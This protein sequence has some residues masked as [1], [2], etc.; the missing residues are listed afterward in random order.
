MAATAEKSGKSEIFWMNGVS[1][2]EQPLVFFPGVDGGVTTK[3]PFSLGP[4]GTSTS[5]KR[6][7]KMRVNLVSNCKSYNTQMKAGKKV[8]HLQSDGSGSYTKERVSVHQSAAVPE[9]HTIFQPPQTFH[10]LS[11]VIS[12]TSRNKSE[13]SLKDLCLADKK[14]IANLVEELARVSEEKEESVQR[15]KD[16]QGNFGRKIHQLEQQNVI[17]EQERKSLQQQYRECQEL[18]GLYQQY[19]SQQQAK[20]NESIA[21]VSQPPTHSKVV[22]G[23]GAP[24]RTSASRANGSLSDGSYVS[25]AA[26]GAQQTQMCS[27]CDARSGA[28][29][30]LPNPACLSC[31]RELG[32][33]DGSAE[34]HTSQRRECRVPR[35]C[36]RS[37]R[38]KI[39]RRDT[40]NGA[41]D[42][43]SDSGSPL[44]NNHQDTFS[45]KEHER[46]SR[47]REVVASEGKDVLTRTLLGQE[48]WEKKRHQLLLQ[49][50]QLEM[51]RERLQARLTEQEERL[52][53]QTKSGVDCS[54]TQLPT[55]A[56]LSRL[57]TGNG[58]P[59]LEGSSHQ[60]LP[61]SVCTDEET[62]S[63]G[64]SL[65][66]KHSQTAPSASKA[67]NDLLERSRKDTGTSPLKSK[68]NSAP[69]I[70]KTPQARLDFSV[71]ELLDIFSPISTSEQPKPSARRPKTFRHGSTFTSSN[72]VGRI[73]LNPGGPYPH[74]THQDLEESQILEDIF[75]IC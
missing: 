65:H 74:N 2:K 64:H 14:R 1:D 22:S 60:D 23:E 18:L 42:W 56:E 11:E 66:E 10:A 48:D 54:R 28:I 26:T 35:T 69:D 58:G 21:Q 29:Q 40:G 43:K 20:L 45:L 49:K 50:M 46:A 62:R 59:E 34:Q 17:I 6:G 24:S 53:R 75:F 51:E 44:L 68:A 25:L 19:L 31:D 12:E 27:S 7:T 5:I 13:V 61:R 71:V 4:D 32:P 3:P 8:G 30:M 70:P 52:N 57:N 63:V 67:R 15:L 36:H 73:L 37:Q 41:Q 39:N 16:E 72:S 47:A 9:E 33:S 55:H 38:S